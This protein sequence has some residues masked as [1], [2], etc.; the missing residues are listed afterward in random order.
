MFKLNVYSVPTAI[1]QLMNKNENTN[2]RK[3]SSSHQMDSEMSALVTTGHLT[4]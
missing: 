4:F 3:A 2:Y 1:I